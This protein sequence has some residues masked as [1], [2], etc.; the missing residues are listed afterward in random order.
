MMFFNLIVTFAMLNKQTRMKITKKKVVG[1]NVELVS[2]AKV[3]SIDR[4]D[5]KVCLNE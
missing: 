5:L 3:M 1:S 4:V 2:C